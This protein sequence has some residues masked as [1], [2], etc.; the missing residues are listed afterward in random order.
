[1]QFA[2]P[3]NPQFFN[4]GQ[5]QQSYNQSQQQQSYQFPGAPAGAFVNPAFFQQQQQMQQ[6]Q[7]QQQQAPAASAQTG[8]PSPEAIQ[9]AADLWR[10]LQQ[11]Q[12]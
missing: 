2:W 10:R 5:Q 4:Q 11:Q 7:Q 1:M 12:Q 3:P 6:P 8:G 9:A